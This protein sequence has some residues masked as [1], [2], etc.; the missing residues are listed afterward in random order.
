MMCGMNTQND[1]GA[2]APARG[3]RVLT[4]TLSRKFVA[5]ALVTL[6]FLCCNVGSLAA[7]ELADEPR[8]GRT[9]QARTPPPPT[10]RSGGVVKATATAGTSKK[11][12]TQFKKVRVQSVSKPGLSKPVLRLRPPP[13]APPPPAL[14]PIP[15]IS[16][17]FEINDLDKRPESDPYRVIDS[18][19]PWQATPLT[20]RVPRAESYGV[21]GC[22]CRSCSSWHGGACPSCRCTTSTA[23]S[24]WLPFMERPTCPTTTR[25]GHSKTRGERS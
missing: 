21:T 1:G 12:G 24:S 7:E 8:G 2:A 18:V 14:P 17:R 6:V 23:F 16:P 20:Q 15:E 25:W 3:K 22:N 4:A 19:Q 10:H 13:P 5:T 9:L 11:T